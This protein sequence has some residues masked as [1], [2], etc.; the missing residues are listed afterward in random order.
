[1]FNPTIARITLRAL[2]GRRRF[3]LLIPLPLLLVGIASAFALSGGD[4]EVWFVPVV[5]AL[6]I[7]VVLPINAL[8]IGT[9]VLGSE[10]D[11]G[12]LAHI[13]AKP[14]A[15]REIIL[16]KLVVSV[17]VT[18][19]VTAVPLA[20]AGLIAGSG[21]LAGALAVGAFV[22]SLVYSAFFAWLSVATR[23]PVLVGLAYILIWESLLT[24][25]LSGTR[26]LSIYQY[27]VTVAD[28]VSGS[29]LVASS[30]SLSVALAMIFILTVGFTLLAIDRLKSFAVQGETS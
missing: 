3:L 2:F 21:A 26:V 4:P 6:G 25:I 1:M 28:R 23:R 19:V 10:I 22:G 16:S 24:T 20:I 18:T 12:T 5:Q 15:R 27:V 13:L 7:A 8:V 14:L 29:T 11:D 30:V 9:G 17:G